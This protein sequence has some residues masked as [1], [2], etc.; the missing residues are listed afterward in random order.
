MD[1]RPTKRRGPLAW[2]A[3]RTWLF[4]VG[5]VL[6][7]VAYAVSFGPACW[8]ASLTGTHN[9]R[10]MSAIFSPIAH[11]AADQNG[12]SRPLAPA[13]PCCR[14]PPTV[15]TAFSLTYDEAELRELIPSRRI[16]RQAS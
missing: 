4:R 11:V 9:A 12:R 6:L 3:A 1:E 5:V 2:L 14:V 7:P 15:R 8:I 13:I 10:W 16:L